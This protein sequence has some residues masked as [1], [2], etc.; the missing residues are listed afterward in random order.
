M[1]FRLLTGRRLLWFTLILL[2]GW[3][4]IK[5]IRFET[6]GYDEGVYTVGVM[7]IV[8]KVLSTSTN[9]FDPHSPIYPSYTWG[10]KP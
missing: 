4:L 10:G 7:R 8:S 2:T 5:D 3:Y 9:L 1:A 6:L